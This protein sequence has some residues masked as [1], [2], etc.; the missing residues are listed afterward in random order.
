[1]RI[2]HYSFGRIRIQGTDYTKDVIILRNRILSPWWREAGGHVFAVRDLGEVIGARADVV[3]LGTGSSGLVEVRQEALE[4]LEDAGSEVIR[5]R[6][7]KAVEAYNRLADAQRD[8]V[9]A[10]HLTC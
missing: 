4:A 2:E 6:T 5:A 3:V 1:V 8:V 7:A 10:L 9:A